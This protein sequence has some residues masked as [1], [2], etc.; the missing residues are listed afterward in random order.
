FEESRSDFNWDVT[1]QPIY[2]EKPNTY[3]NASV[4]LLGISQTSKHKEAALQV[5]EYLTSDEVQMSLSKAGTVS[6]VNKEE[7]TAAF[8]S[9]HPKLEGKHVTDIFLSK[10]IPYP[11]YAY[12]NIG[13]KH[14]K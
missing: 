13:E 1:Q 6:T 2:V 9:D 8:A 14:I 11:I 4:Y 12:R 5:I 7:I 3:G 10:A